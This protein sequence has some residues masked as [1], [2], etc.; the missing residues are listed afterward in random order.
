MQLKENRSKYQKLKNIF[1]NF[2][3]YLLLLAVAISLVEIG[4]RVFFNVSYDLFFSF[5]IWISIWS[6]L[7]ITGLVLEEGGHLSIDFI[8]NKIVGRPR[9][10]HEIVIALVT[11]GYG[12]LITWG[13]VVFIYQL[14]Q[15]KSVVPNYIAIPKWMVE[16]CVP[17]GMAIFSVFA[18]VALIK[19]IR[20]KW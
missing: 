6:L 17:I 9:K 19:A 2:C 14:Y 13:S 20:E 16:L 3:G 1:E 15:R 4:A 10:L 12:V 8:R 7:L 18:I 11:L 5:T